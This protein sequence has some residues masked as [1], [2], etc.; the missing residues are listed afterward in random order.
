MGNRVTESLGAARWATWMLTGLATF[1]GTALAVL[2]QA[3]QPA[4]E[5]LPAITQPSRVVG[6]TAG[7]EEAAAWQQVQAATDPGQRAQLAQQFLMQFPDSGMTPHAH[8][9]IAQYAYQS[10]DFSTFATH[11]EE[12]LK[13]LPFAIDLL[14]QLAFLYAEQNE[15]DK[16]VNRA[17]EALRV[18]ES[19][20]RPAEV[21]PEIWVEQAYQVRAEA[22]YALGRAHLSRLRSGARSDDPNLLQA[23]EYFRTALRYDPRHDYAAFRLGFALRNVSDVDGALRAYGRAVAV[24][25]VTA[26]L[27]RGQIDEVLNIVKRAMPDSDWA[28][29]SVDDVV[30][31]AQAELLQETARV[32]AE[33]R[34]E[35]DRL[36]MQQMPAETP[37]GPGE[38]GGALP[39]TSPEG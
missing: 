17:T 14:S 21:S 3:E 15:P 34:G 37:S 13:E 25:G 36:M 26:E 7:P 35:V 27:A 28:K 4:Q 32:Q 20:Q 6:R 12:A 10:G 24:G 31:E 5:E 38:G 8:Y 11:A 29:K 18:L 23:I 1:Q 9:V 19:L 33:K 22:N 2:Q 39:P 16:A 30:A